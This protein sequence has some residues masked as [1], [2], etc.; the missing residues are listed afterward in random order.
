MLGVTAAVPMHCELQR[1]L[2]E[3]METL[4]EEEHEGE[5]HEGDNFIKN[6]SSIEKVV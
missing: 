5:E 1:R 3:V 2:L 6:P 4:K